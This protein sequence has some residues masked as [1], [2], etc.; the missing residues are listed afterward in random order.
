MLK[1]R[2]KKNNKAAD[3]NHPTQLA[4]R[5]AQFTN[6]TESIKAHWEEHKWDWKPL[7]FSSDSLETADALLGIANALRGAGG[8]FVEYSF[9][10]TLGY[11]YGEVL[12]RSL[13]GHWERTPQEFREDTPDNQEWCVEFAADGKDRM[14]CCPTN[15]VWSRLTEADMP[16]LP[17]QYKIAVACLDTMKSGIAA[18][19]LEDA[20]QAKVQPLDCRLS[21]TTR[22]APTDS[23]AI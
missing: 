21:F 5:F 7:D 1:N 8:G 4:E 2:K 11:Y 6:A 23:V 16:S 3:H 12:V 13:G 14:L 9:V 17:E 19:K 15:G 22:E 10:T 18:D 20:L